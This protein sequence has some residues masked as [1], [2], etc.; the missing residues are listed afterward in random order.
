MTSTPRYRRAPQILTL[1][2]F[3]VGALNYSLIACAQEMQL[4]PRVCPLSPSQTQNAIAAYA[5]MFPT[6][7]QQP[8]CVNCH[9]GVNPFSDEHAGGPRAKG[10]QDATPGCNECHSN[11]PS[12]ANGSPGKWTLPILPDHSFVNRTAKS[13][14]ESM[15]KVSPTGK[16]FEGHIDNDNGGTNFNLVAFEGT[17]GLNEEGQ[18]LAF[19]KPS[20]TPHPIVGITHDELKAQ[21]KAWV[22]AMGGEF[23]G[24]ERCGCE[25][26]HQAI[27]LFYVAKTSLMGV[28]QEVGIMG[29]VDIPITFHDDR[30]FEG[31]GPFPFRAGGADRACVSQSQGQMI[32][33]VTGSAEEK[34]SEHKMHFDVMEVTPTAGGTAVQ[35]PMYS[36]GSFLRG[37]NLPPPQFDMLGAVGEEKRRIVP[38]PTPVV[39]ASLCAKVIDLD[40]KV[41]GITPEIPQCPKIK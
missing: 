7:T 32:I 17:R 30:T 28:V 40:P 2:L 35:C 39:D 15:K 31:Q 25:P 21:A 33:K 36:G 23:E 20:Y 3:L 34:T 4:V 18:A 1:A 8:R 16:H 27:R 29:P 6:F 12:K 38:L 13:L 5:K 11:L 41:E 19:D 10:E 26:V 37:G 24:D 14:C 22:D 9:G